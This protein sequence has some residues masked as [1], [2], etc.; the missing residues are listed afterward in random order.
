MATAVS[1]RTNGRKRRGQRRARHSAE[2]R[3]E[4]VEHAMR[5][6]TEGV[7][8]QQSCREAGITYESL[9]RWRKEFSASPRLRPVKTGRGAAPRQEPATSPCLV[10]AA[11]HRIEGLDIAQLVDLV[12]ALG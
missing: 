7:S 1:I 11:G 3:R 2:Q 6:L 12:R 5:R 4:V 8:L 10:T 9:R